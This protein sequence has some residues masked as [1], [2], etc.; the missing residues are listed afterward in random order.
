MCSFSTYVC[1]CNNLF[2]FF[3]PFF[4]LEGVESNCVD[5]SQVLLSRASQLVVVG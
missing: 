3:G 2:L 4:L 1:F 5:L